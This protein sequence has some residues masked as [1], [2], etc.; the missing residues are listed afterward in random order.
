LRILGGWALRLA[1]AWAVAITAGVVA[2]AVAQVA[3]GGTI[4]EIRVDGTQRVEPETVRSYLLVQPGDQFDP[5]R[6]DRSLK[7]LF[8]TGLF[9]DVTLRRDGN[10]LVVTVV[11][12]PVINR[13]AFE[14][15]RK[16]NDDTLNQEIQLR[17]R[18]VYTRQKVQ[19]DVRRILDLY[20]R[21]GRF[22]ATVEPKVVPLPQNRV[23]LVFE[24]DEGPVTGVRSINFVGN[25]Q[26]GAGRLREV[27]QTKETRW[28]RFF[29]TDDTYD[30]DRLTYDRELLRKFYLSEGYADFRV[31]SAVAELTPARDGFFITFTIEEGERYKF[32]KVDIANQ[33]KDVDPAELTALLTTHEG[34]WYNADEVDKSISAL[35]DA[36]GNRGYAFVEI[37]PRV[38][39]N[40]DT[41]TIDITYDVKEGPRVYVERIDIS[42]NLR[43]LDRV[44]RREFRLVEGDAFNTSKL[45]RSQQRIKN[46]G[47]FKKAEVTNKPGS[48]PD[49]TVITAEVQEQSTGEFSVGVGFSTTDGA[50][51]D[52][53]IRERNLLGKGQDLRIGALVAQ[54]TQQIDLSFTEPY[55]LDRNLSAGFDLFALVRDN[56]DIA[57]FNQ[58][59][60][61]GSLRAGYQITEPLRQTLKYTLRQDRIF[62]VADAASTFI[63]EQTG[64]R[65]TS[66]VGQVLL[67]DKRDNRLD[68]TSGYF[69]SIGTEIAG[70]GVGVRYFRTT[71][72]GGYYY[73]VAPAW[74]LSVTGDA[75]YI[76]GLGDRVRIEDRFFVGGDNLRG[77]ASGGIGPRASDNNDALG[78]NIYYVGSVALS[79]PL[80]LPQELGLNGR[81]F[82]DF[83][84]LWKVDPSPNPSTLTPG[85]FVRDVNSIRVSAGAGVSW[86]SPLG[87]IRL[88]FALPVKRESFDKKE[89]FRVSFGTRF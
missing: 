64:S 23:D 22:A 40:P 52:I 44:I 5:D 88:D 67:Y 81:V 28:Y 46:L 43:T 77:F 84:S 54:R 15:N 85:A 89:F 53:G 12:N 2:P 11:E 86:Q 41:R 38:R 19:S 83:G 6:L 72:S 31:V 60:V 8:A 35:T 32:G 76:F 70:V 13:I 65:I 30:P 36:L 9:A 29:T 82:S 45:Q 62:D 80:G 61:G 4:Q 71:L 3:P 24:I 7:A 87:P 69:G 51:A 78:G 75:G 57:G 26:F 56:Q 79:F 33:L 34:D 16:L 73:P 58:Q 63:K 21:N 47:F 27:I 10:S 55:F 50:L 17:P 20:R 42:G 74:V 48:A 1:L 39:R 14:G 68:P 59:S 37:E 18:V 25:R 49:R 66:S